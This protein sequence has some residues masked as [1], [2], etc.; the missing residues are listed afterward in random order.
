LLTSSPSQFIGITGE[1]GFGKTTLL[2]VLLG[3]AGIKSS[4]E[5]SLIGS[6][7]YA[8]QDPWIFPGTLKANILNQHSFKSDWYDA[9]I[10][11]CALT[12][13][14]ALL[15]QGDSTD[16]GEQGDSL[17][18]GQKTRVNLARAVMQENEKLHLAHR[19]A[20]N[21]CDRAFGTVY[22]KKKS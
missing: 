1:V 4:E 7:S 8:P 13:D 21:H 12:Q 9:V 17:S 16:V 2:N 14:I 10:H 11:A 3:E 19:F 15:P 22:Q 6:I 5:L 18:G 20:N